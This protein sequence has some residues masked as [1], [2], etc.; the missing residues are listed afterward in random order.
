MNYNSEDKIL[1][2]LGLLFLVLS[3]LTLTSQKNIKQMIHNL[4]APILTS[5]NQKTTEKGIILKGAKLNE[6]STASIIT[7]SKFS[8]DV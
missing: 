7:L 1:D 5:L 2:Q 6:K 8:K 3:F 4:E